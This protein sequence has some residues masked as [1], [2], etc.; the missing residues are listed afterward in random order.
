LTK[1]IKLSSLKQKQK[2]KLK[3]KQKQQQH[4]QQMVLVQLEGSM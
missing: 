4:F 3:Q 1:E 2:Q